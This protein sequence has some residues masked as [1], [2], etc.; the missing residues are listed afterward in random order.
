MDCV[1]VH[2]QA[3]LRGLSESEAESEDAR[4]SPWQKANCEP[5]VSR[6][7]GGDVEEWPCQGKKKLQICSVTTAAEGPGWRLP[8]M[9]S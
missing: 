1:A 8:G 3:Q 2:T 7:P 5:P 6:E 9:K 4:G